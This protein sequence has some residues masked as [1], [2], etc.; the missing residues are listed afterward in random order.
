M[1]KK[2]ILSDLEALLGDMGHDL[3]NLAQKA[4]DDFTPVEM[5]SMALT[6]VVKGLK[7][8]Y[9]KLQAVVEKHK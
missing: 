4:I 2:E 1:T 5:R 6:D 3:E 8:H 7:H 9:D